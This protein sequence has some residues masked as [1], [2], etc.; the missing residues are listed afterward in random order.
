MLSLTWDPISDHPARE[1]PGEYIHGGPDAPEAFLSD[2]GS[3]MLI[4]L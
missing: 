4:S 1:F 3:L 2:I